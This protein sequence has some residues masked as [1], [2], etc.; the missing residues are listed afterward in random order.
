M[1]NITTY[2]RQDLIELFN[3]DR[4]DN[5]KR[6]L[7][8]LGYEYT[9][10]GRG[11]ELKVTIT[12]TP[13]AFKMFCINELGIPPQ[14]DF[15]LLRT[16]FY[17]FFCDDEFK[18]LPI[19][20]MAKVL[21]QEGQPICRQ[22]ISKWI[23]YLSQKEIINISTDNYK[24]YVSFSTGLNNYVEEIGQEEYKKA[25]RK[26]WSVRNGGGTYAEAFNA[27]CRVNGGTVFKK[28]QI[29]ENAF[30]ASTINNLIDLLID[31][32]DGE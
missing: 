30:Y 23:E 4:L 28:P 8:R 12:Q 27:M 24:Y 20:Q 13:N 2:S 32:L 31:S 29:E 1:L 26:Y 10:S 9:T 17:Y 19:A 3:T 15:V 5:I 6:S 21:E 11:K 18:Q 22:T 14:S 16:F 25:W 7:S